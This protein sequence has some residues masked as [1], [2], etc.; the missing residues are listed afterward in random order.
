M[1]AA[2]VTGTAVMVN[3]WIVLAVHQVVMSTLT[4]Q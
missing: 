4:G 1:T 2:R 3:V